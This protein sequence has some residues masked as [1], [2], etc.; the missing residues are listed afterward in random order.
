[1][2]VTRDLA[3]R[4]A[5]LARGVR[6]F[7]AVWGGSLRLRF[8]VL[9][10]VFSS[11]AVA[12]VGLVLMRQITGSLLDAK[13]DA[14]V[15]EVSSAYQ[16]VRSDIEG[17]DPD[18]E[19]FRDQ[20]NRT[21]NSISRSAVDSSAQGSA[22]GVYEAAIIPAR[23]PALAVGPASDIPAELIARVM[24]GHLSSQYITIDRDGHSRSALVVGAPAVASNEV[25]G[26]YLI[27]PLTAEEQTLGVVQRII[28]FGGAALLLALGAIALAVG[29][30]VVRPVRRAADVAERLADGNLDERM[31]VKG[32]IEVA[33]LAR[34][35]NGMAA[36]IKTQIRELEHLG[37]L[38]RRFTSDVSH[39]L[40]TPV[41][42][43]RMAADVLYESRETFPADLARTT[44]LLVAEL[45]R[46]ETLL[47]DLLEISRHDAGMVEL[48]CEQVDLRTTI[49]ECVSAMRPLADKAAVPLITRLPEQPVCAE[50]DVRRV[51]RILRNLLGNAID[52]AGGLPVIVELAAD[53]QAVAICVA[54]QGVG[55]RPGEA[56]LVFHRFWRADPS[57]QRH[58][59]GTGLGLAI[60][61]EDARLH[62]GWL[63]A[64]GA[65]GQGSRFRLTLP[66]RHGD[67]VASSPLPLREGADDDIETSD[68]E[69]FAAV[70]NAAVPNRIAIPAPQGEI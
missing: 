46:F 10:V 22:A 66:I 13:R 9:T 67:Q 49:D 8:T 50:V 41:T 40:R 12:G 2:T 69:T 30:Q 39:E 53:D 62:G 32:A 64:C 34:S 65:P 61:L 6:S 60:S 15:A 38:Q 55:L 48:S 45:D 27:F 36:A 17:A 29:R 21:R 31:E 59:G 7:L 4:W 43:V 14:A 3:G 1:M 68:N 42:T 16:V 47:A 18:P 24:S 11:V 57:R 25:L 51:E 56:S 23:N 44:E 70:I 26:V 63:Q 33:S 52:H 58:T 5:Y 37:R 35:F 28:M 54:D 19:R 20:L